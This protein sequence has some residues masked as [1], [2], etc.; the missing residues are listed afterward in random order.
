MLKESTSLGSW[1][2][3]EGFVWSFVWLALNVKIPC[4][5]DRYAIGPTKILDFGLETGRSGGLIHLI[6]HA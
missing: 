4:S 2:D 5:G 3:W 1:L 6:A